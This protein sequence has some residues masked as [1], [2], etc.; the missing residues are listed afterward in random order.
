MK[1]HDY[2]LN[3]ILTIIIIQY[4]YKYQGQH[5]RTNGCL[6]QFCNLGYQ[7]MTAHVFEKCQT[8]FSFFQISFH[9]IL[10][11][12]LIFGF[13]KVSLPTHFVKTGHNLQ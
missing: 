1:F 9:P 13:F 11:K 8:H 3:Q 7:E 6:N 5:L 2:D 4:N 10:L 12:Q